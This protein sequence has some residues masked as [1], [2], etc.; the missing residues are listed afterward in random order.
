MTRTW[1]K[2]A[3]LLLMSV[4]LMPLLMGAGGFNPGIPTGTKVGGTLFK[5]S[6]VIDPH[7]PGTTTTAGR[8]SIRLYRDP[9]LASAIFEIPVLGFPLAFGCDLSKTDVRFLNVPL[10]NWIPAD[11]LDQLVVSLRTPR[12]ARKEPVITHIESDAC[13]P[14]PANPTPSDGSHPGILSFQA[15]VRFLVPK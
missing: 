5:V 14:D 3:A 6:V 7:N 12:N 1:F 13:T 10:I 11:V 8:A 15:D 2:R 9:L 4:V